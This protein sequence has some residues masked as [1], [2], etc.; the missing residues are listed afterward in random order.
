MRA[1]SAISE[2]STARRYDVIRHL[3][4]GMVRRKTG[5]TLI[6]GLLAPKGHWRT[7]HLILGRSLSTRLKLHWRADG[8]CCLVEDQKRKVSIL[9]CGVKQKWGTWW[10][11][12]GLRKRAGK[13]QPR[14][15]RAKR[16]RWPKQTLQRL[17]T[18]SAAPTKKQWRQWPILNLFDAGLPSLADLHKM[19]DGLPA[20][21]GRTAAGTCADPQRA[22]WGRSSPRSQLSK[23]NT[24]EHGVSDAWLGAMALHRTIMKGL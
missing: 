3:P 22:T 2:R 20:N 5:V 6:E 24:A 1:P 10:L 19:P 14:A 11:D 23:N 8:P 9:G 12:K 18:P 16:S 7:A 15:P 17:P 21:H 4:R 13:T